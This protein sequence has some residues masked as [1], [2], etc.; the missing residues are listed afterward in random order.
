MPYL[1][2]VLATLLAGCAPRAQL[3]SGPYGSHG[4]VPGH[5]SLQFV[6]DGDSGPD[7]LFLFRNDATEA[8]SYEYRSDADSAPVP[9]CR[10][11]KGAIRVCAAPDSADNLVQ[12]PLSQERQLQ[13][14]V[15]VIFGA[16]PR[17]EEDVGI[18]IIVAGTPH[19]L[20]EETSFDPRSGLR[21]KP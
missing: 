5:V 7:P 19:H 9:Y 17:K 6:P 21:Q 8:V 20:W 13:P 4:P 11:P 16:F 14:K 10:A 2:F 12:Y 18:R 3:G 1:V 15:I